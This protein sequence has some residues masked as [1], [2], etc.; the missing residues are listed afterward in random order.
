MPLCAICGIES[1]TVTRDHIPPKGLFGKPLPDNLITVPACP[2]CNR[3]AS[4]DDEYFRL[5]AVEWDASR[6]GDAAGVSASIIRS[7]QRQAARGFRQSVFGSIQ[8]VMVQTKGGL[9]LP[10][11]SITVNTERL[12]RTVE[13]TIKG[14]YFHASSEPLPAGSSV[15]ARV[16]E[17]AMQEETAAVKEELRGTVLPSLAEQP[18]VQIGGDIFAFRYARDGDNPHCTAWWLEFYRRFRFV[19]LTVPPMSGL[20]GY[21]RAKGTHIGEQNG[22]TRVQGF[23]CRG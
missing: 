1:L 15:W 3:D 8:R 10:A 12:L 6:V 13:K 11:F 9:V 18:E 23:T 14:L 19:G 21:R 2:Q 17:Q 5:L 20:H 16:Y 7:M 22:P 4:G